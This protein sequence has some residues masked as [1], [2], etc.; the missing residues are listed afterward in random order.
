MALLKFGILPRVGGY[1]PAGFE[2]R[3]NDQM[4]MIYIGCHQEVASSLNDMR[5]LNEN[6]NGLYPEMLQSELRPMKNGYMQKIN[7]SIFTANIL[8]GTAS[9]IGH[10][11]R[12]QASMITGS[13]SY[14][15]YARKCIIT[16]LHI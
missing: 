7:I 5:P 13:L 8:Q 16:E 9:C 11:L 12:L 10:S 4:N 15:A 6:V 14:R 2:G 3:L 1:V